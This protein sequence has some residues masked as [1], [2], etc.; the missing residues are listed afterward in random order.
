MGVYGQ[1]VLIRE[2]F[3]NWTDQAVAGSYS[4]TKKLFDGTTD[5]TFT[6]SSLIVESTKTIGSA[7]TAIGN[8]NPSVGR[9]AIAGT[10]SY[11]TLP[12]LPSIGTVN[13]KM[14]PGTT[15]NGYKLQVFDGISTWTDIPGTAT[16][17][18]KL[19][20][21]LYTHN[22][23]YTSPTQIRIIASQ[24]GSVNIWDVEVYSNPATLPLLSAPTTSSATSVLAESFTANWTSNDANATGYS[25]K[26]Y[27]ST[28]TLVK[29]VTVSG[30]SA[31]SINITG[32]LV[33]TN[34]TYTVTAIADGINYANSTESNSTSFSTESTYPASINTNFSNG[35]WGTVYVSGSTPSLGGYPVYSINGWDLT[36]AYI[37]SGTYTGPRGEVHS[38]TLRLDKVI[39]SGVLYL[40][41]VASVS[42]IEIHSSASATRQFILEVSTNG[43]AYTTVGTYTN[44]DGLERID[45]IPI[46][47]TNAKFRITNPSSGAY[48]FYQIITRTTNPSLLTTVTNG[49]ADA[50]AATSATLN[51][52]PVVNASGGYK[53]YLYKSTTLQSGY[54]VSV[55]GQGSTSVTINGI[56]PNT[57]YNYKV[58]AIG[59]GDV[60]FSDSYLST[61]STFTTANTF[62][63]TGS[64]NASALNLNASSNI[65]IGSTGNLTINGN[66]SAASITVNPN[67]RLTISPTFTLS[68]AINLQSDENGTATLV[69]ETGTQELTGT[70]QQYLSTTRNWYISSPISNAV[71]PVGYTYF[72]RDEAGASWTSQ[73]FVA[74]NTFAVGRGY[75]ALPGSTASVISFSTESGGKIN[76]GDVSIGLT[77]G[78]NGFNLIGNPYPSHLT[79][80]KAF[81]QSKSALID[82]T[83]WYR[84]NSGA[85]NTGGWSFITYNAVSEEGTPSTA[86]GI[87][88][89]MQAFWV[90]AVA[91]GTLILNSDLT[92]SHQA[93]NPLKA[94]AVKNSNRQRIR[95]QIDNGTATDEALIYFDASALDTYDRYDSQKITESNSETQIYTTIGAEKLVING[96]NAIQLDTP[97]GL[98]FVPG[99]GTSFSIKANEI[100]NLPSDV[101]VILK[102]NVTLAETDLTDGFSTYSF[103]PEITS[104][105]RFS[106]IFRTSGAVTGLMNNTDNSMLVYYNNN[107]ELIIKT[108]NDKL[109][110]SKVSVYNALGQQLINTKLSGVTM[111]IDFPYAPN[112]YFVKVDNVL[113]KVTVK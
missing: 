70:V 9:V 111:N 82:P 91:A 31:S 20:T 79:W 113:K 62:S 101:R 13:I 63:I 16:A 69:D 55:S 11:L 87:I 32:L 104:V 39:N 81:V 92:R 2:N 33:N 44:S 74:T 98:C 75:I 71:A 47:A 109:I 50:V 12:Q 1:V 64:S 4:I 112:V 25:V 85:S 84:T 49:V 90:K 41:T 51:W 3:Q 78:T 106:I 89:P 36:H 80:T 15:P 23:S 88:P 26:V 19:I 66:T 61:N 72:Q 73:P 24:G 68:S 37:Q 108:N 38:H 43:G 54:P 96:M 42:Q 5:G 34:Y 94:P 46:T 22:L 65:T 58:Q 8:G 99:S 17:G 48:T 86:N 60:D 52:T 77:K 59:N 57:E 6:A 45:I 10:T 18:D 35:T 14:N 110:G 7:G 67:G 100:S 53:V 56:T 27:N 93:S 105:D 97:I 102:D 40:P 107:H 95:L 21:K 103:S 30:Q 76:T 83:I 29:T 28:P